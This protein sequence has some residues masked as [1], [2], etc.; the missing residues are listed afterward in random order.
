MLNAYLVLVVFPLFSVLLR[1]S[2]NN[3]LRCSL[4]SLFVCD[5]LIVFPPLEYLGVV[6]C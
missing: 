1:D 5:F 3:S 4:F 2:R 6:F